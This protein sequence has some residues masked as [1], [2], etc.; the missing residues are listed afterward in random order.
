MP[1]VSI[2]HLSFTYA[3]MA[4]P[5]LSQ[6]SLRIV[7]GEIVLLT[8]PSG[9][10]KSTLALALAGL[11][12]TRISGALRGGIFLDGTNISQ[13]NIHEISQQI[14]IV[15][16]NPDNQLI[17]LSVEEEVA[18]GP[19]NLALPPEEIEKRVSEALAAT[20]MTALRHE[21]IFALSGGQKQRV[22]IAATLSMRPHILVLDEPTSDLD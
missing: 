1:E 7:P 5:V 18:F 10:G 6:I 15:F 13:L 14:G 20:G 19:E 17:Q 3:G 16:Q 11:I 8:G 2:D 22:A 12:P 9:C 4:K 21:Q